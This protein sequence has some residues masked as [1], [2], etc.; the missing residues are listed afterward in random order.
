MNIFKA[1]DIRGVYGEDLTEKEAYALG[2]ACGDWLRAPVC[3]VAG[4]VRLSTP[5]LK[6]ALSDGLVQAGCRVTDAGVLTTPAFYYAVQR[7]GSTLGIMV[8]ASHN[9]AAYNG[10]KILVENRPIQEEELA[11]LR[12]LMAAGTFTAGAGHY[13]RDDEWLSLYRKE[14][15]RHFRPEQPRVRSGTDKVSLQKPRV[16]LDCGNGACSLLAPEIFRS[17]GY[18]VEELFCVPD[19]N[20]PNR[21]PNPAVAENL[22]IL[23]RQ[24]SGKRDAVGIAYDGDGDR[25]AFVSESGQMIENDRL[26]ILFA[27]HLL[28]REKGVIVYDSKCSMAVAEE[29]ERLGG[30]PRIARSG[31]GFVRT[32]F[33]AAKALLAGEL[34]GHFFW[35]ALLFD[36]AIFSSLMLLDLLQENGQSL[37]QADAALPRYLITPDIRL[38]FAGDAQA[39]IEDMAQRLSGFPLSRLDGVRVELPDCWGMVRPSVTE[40]II[41]L[42]F[43]G[44]NEERLHFISEQV[45]AALPEDVRPDALA[46]LGKV[47]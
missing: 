27:R 4:D 45:L 29:I 18:E 2:R 42:R 23:R 12:D 33:L 35:R 25:V 46:A 13:R 41:T 5:V 32:E 28:T 44:K 39:L 19:G 34:S 8:T 17:S 43:E 3:L 11:L 36:D 22:T 10:F 16:V 31:H 20:F 26:L 24:M 40:P 38:P 14:I 9:P 21:P 1:C 6:A 7:T 37:A 30:T 47:L 15:L